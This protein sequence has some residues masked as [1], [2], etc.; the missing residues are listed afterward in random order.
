[1]LNSFS[2]AVT[3]NG[4]EY[5]T[6][7]AL[8]R[9]LGF[10]KD[11]IYS[12]V[13][14]GMTIEEAV[15]AGIPNWRVTVFGKEYKNMTELAKAH[16]LKVRDIWETKK[17]YKIPL[18]EI[19]LK[20]KARRKIEFRGQTFESLVTLCAH[21]NIPSQAVSSRLNKGL[22][23][24]EA[25]TK[26][27]REKRL[28]KP[29]SYRGID[30]PSTIDFVTAHGFDIEFFKSTRRRVKLTEVETMDLLLEFFSKYGKR[31]RPKVIHCIPYAIHDGVWYN[32]YDSFVTSIGL[33]TIK[34]NNF[35]K[36]HKKKT[37][38]R[39]T[40]KRAL[41]LMHETQQSKYPNLKY[42]PSTLFTPK[43]DFDRLME[44]LSTKN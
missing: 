27:F 35:I 28:I 43:Q 20:L 1:M 37:G 34:L 39:L 33:E 42:D 21:Y 40:I 19:I 6:I 24:E 12:R 36:Y 30:Y 38:T 29:I 15:K 5:P 13:Y 2:G 8:E 14:R 44:K 3:Y 26:P 23:L 16:G 22:T 17:R 41:K 32:T 25:I 4:K 7:R 31:N 10:P 18:E 9:A 11:L